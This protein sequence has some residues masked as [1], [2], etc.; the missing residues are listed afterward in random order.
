MKVKIDKDDR[1]YIYCKGCHKKITNDKLSRK[2]IG[3]S[4]FSEKIRTGKCPYCNFAN[5][6]K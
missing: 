5:I 6:L 2:I 3:V 4:L 1:G